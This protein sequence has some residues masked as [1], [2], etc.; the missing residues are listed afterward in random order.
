MTKKIF[1]GLAF[2]ALLTACTDDYKDWVS[3]EKVAQPE[4]VSFADGSVSAV[5]VIKMA[6]LVD[7][8]TM[9]KVCN[10][11][12]PTASVSG[13]TPI[14]SIS[15]NGQEFALEEDGTMFVNELKEY[16]EKT[17]G[18]APEQ[19]EI[20]ATVSA[21]LN[22]GNTSV[23]TA[24]SAAFPVKVLLDAP[25][26]DSG[27]W[28]VGDMLGWDAAGAKPFTHKGSGD[29]YEAPEFQIVFKTTADNQYWKI[30]PQG[31]YDGDF[32][33]GGDTG[34][35]GTV[36]DGDTSMEG[37]L[38]TQN[39]QAG[40]IEKAGIYR[41]TINMMEYKY[42]IEKLEFA[43]YIYFIGATDGWSN[44]EQKLATLSFD[45][46]YTGYIYCADPN[47]WGN[48]FKFQRVAGSWDNEINFDT[49]SGG[50]SGDFVQGGG[51][52]IKANAGEGIYYITADLASGT[53]K[54]VRINNMNLVGD[55]NGWN[56][57]D[58]AQQM[59]W[60]AENYCYVISSSILLVR[61]P[62]R[63]IVRLSNSNTLKDSDYE[64][65][66]EYHRCRGTPYW[67]VHSSTSTRNRGKL[68]L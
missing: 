26:I 27:Y 48:E 33:A 66:N 64:K 39:P 52:N 22:D 19:R 35:L 59:T 28:L 51:S 63:S 60:D 67:S 21:W 54:G 49:F 18:K 61:L 24:T 43:P 58:D 47:N 57:G 1:F 31:N 14:Y 56:P 3:P 4:Q 36:V 55:F 20:E 15:L 41:I 34:V 40:K 30:I 5:D 68:S 37:T 62:T 10:L 45:G 13:Y 32:W 8:Q 12:A 44:A 17:F 38:T 42:K 50:V 2:A 46:V 23:K 11:T 9:V 6:D 29:V 16:V 25:F 65:N 53:L 7:G